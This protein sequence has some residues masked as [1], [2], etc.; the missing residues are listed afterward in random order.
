MFVKEI[1]EK[2]QK[3]MTLQINDTINIELETKEKAT[4]VIIAKNDNVYTLSEF[5]NQGNIFTLDKTTLEL[6][7]VV[8]GKS[9]KLTTIKIIN[10]VTYRPEY[11]INLKD[12]SYGV[13]LTKLVEKPL[14]VGDTFQYNNSQPC[15]V[16]YI[17]E[18]QDLMV[19]KYVNSGKEV[20]ITYDNTMWL[21]NTKIRGRG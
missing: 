9:K 4:L 20:G 7:N 3:T 8:S 10:R 19:V 2:I 12:F 15:M 14:A 13:E 6:K 18:A 5:N 21:K 16:M 11:D 17:S 1:R